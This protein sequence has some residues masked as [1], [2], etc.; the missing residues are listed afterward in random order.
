MTTTTTRHSFEYPTNKGDN[1]GAWG[2]LIA[3]I[4]QALDLRLPWSYAGNPNTNVAG[5][6]VGQPIWDSTNKKDYR[7]TTTGDAATAVW[8]EATVSLVAIP[9]GLIAQWSGTIANIPT[10]WVLCDGT[11]STPDLRDKF[12]IGATQDDSSVAKTNVEGSLTQTGGAT[13]DTSSSAGAHDHGAATG[14]TTLT[15]S[16]IP[17]HTHDE[18][19]LETASDGAHDHDLN[20]NS[21][22]GVDGPFIDRSNGDSSPDTDTT[23]IQSAGAHTHA[24]TG[25]TGSAG[26]GA[27]HDH[28]ISSDGAHTHEVDI[29][30]PYYALAFIMKT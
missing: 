1:A 4:I 26:G 20:V 11:N 12:I 10:G 23:S 2:P 30:P 27:G 28:T 22:S 5:N 14:S 19:T 21:G 6:Y 9:A 29:L 18:G 8:E 24:I 15:T 17:A 13:T 3:D 25:N 16:Q 7:C